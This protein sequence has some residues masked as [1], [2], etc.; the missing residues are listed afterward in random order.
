MV[1]SWLLSAVIWSMQN[2]WR[3]RSYVLEATG[4][5]CCTRKCWNGALTQGR[6]RWGAGSRCRTWEGYGGKS[7]QVLVNIIYSNSPPH[8]KNQVELQLH[9]LLPSRG[10][11]S[12]SSPLLP[13]EQQKFS[14][15]HNSERILTSIKSLG[16]IHLILIHIVLFNRLLPSDNFRGSSLIPGDTGENTEIKHSKV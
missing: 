14:I 5:I 10:S 11:S 3:M 13:E 8:N 9:L 2:S 7:Y 6:E 1:V 4:L 12:S 15:R 16:S